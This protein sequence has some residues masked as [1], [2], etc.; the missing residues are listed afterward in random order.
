MSFAFGDAFKG[1]GQRPNKPLRDV[2]YTEEFEAEYSSRM[3]TQ[4][5]L[6]SYLVTLYNDR[7]ALLA[8]LSQASVSSNSPT[9]AATVDPESTGSGSKATVESSRG[10]NGSANETP[11]FEVKNRPCVT[12]RDLDTR[13]DGAL[14]IVRTDDEVAI[15]TAMR[16]VQTQKLDIA[17]LQREIEWLELANENLQLKLEGIDLGEEIKERKATM[18]EPMD[19]EEIKVGESS[20]GMSEDSES[21]RASIERDE[22]GNVEKTKKGRMDY[23]GSNSAIQEYL[24]YL[25]NPDSVQDYT[26][27]L[28]SQMAESVETMAQKKRMDQRIARG[29]KLVRYLESKNPYIQNGRDTN[30]SHGLPDAFDDTETQK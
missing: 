6:R 22:H 26:K 28:E 7:R 4:T 23:I 8:S 15:R 1:R 10:D 29:E 18:D 21:I 25:E 13:E 24:K 3:E 11:A 9:S 2:P 16:L 12:L 19:W 17:N 14:R 20:K 30:C 27:Y 5:S